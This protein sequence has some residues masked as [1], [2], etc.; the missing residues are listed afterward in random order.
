MNWNRAAKP[1]N[2]ERPTTREQYA[3]AK[4]KPHLEVNGRWW[5]LNEAAK[6]SLGLLIDTIYEDPDL[7]ASASKSTI[8]SAVP[9]PLLGRA[10]MPFSRCD[11]AHQLDS[12]VQNAGN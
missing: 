1:Q 8:S 2:Y 9:S 10:V 3:E 7:K 11:R 6:D 12:I 5:V 4:A